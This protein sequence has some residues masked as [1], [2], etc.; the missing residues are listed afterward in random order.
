MVVDRIP[1]SLFITG[2]RLRSTQMTRES[3]SDPERNSYSRQRIEISGRLNPAQASTKFI[4]CRFR[5]DSVAAAVGLLTHQRNRRCSRAR[6]CEDSPRACTCSGRTS[7]STAYRASSAGVDTCSR[8]GGS[9]A[10]LDAA[11]RTGPPFVL[12]TIHAEPLRPVPSTG[13][14][15]AKEGV[16]SGSWS[17]E[18]FVCCV[19][20]LLGSAFTAAGGHRNDQGQRS[21]AARS[22]PDAEDG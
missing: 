5:R 1:S 6:V 14:R 7:Q 15:G 12:A 20:V 8:S 11:T 19:G 9:S 18:A 3:F 17:S 10:S 21:Q 13:P 4:E 16:P 22:R 2:R